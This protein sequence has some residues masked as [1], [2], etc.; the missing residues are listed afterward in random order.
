MLRYVYVYRTSTDA[1]VDYIYHFWR[2]MMEMKSIFDLLLDGAFLHVVAIAVTGII[3]ALGLITVLLN[4]E[5]RFYLYLA[6][7]R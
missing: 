6:A 4:N 5:G 1:D 7:C 3:G 2:P